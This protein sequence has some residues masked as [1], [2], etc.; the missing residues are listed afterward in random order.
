[1]CSSDLGRKV[2]TTVEELQKEFEGFV[3]NIDKK[4]YDEIEISYSRKFVEYCIAK[5]VKEFCS[6][7]LDEKIAD[8]SF[9]RFTF[10][11]MLAWEMPSSSHLQSSM[12]FLYDIILISC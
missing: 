2:G 4:E 7:K 5:A 1:M 6:D 10:D 3:W 8:G 9:S 11:A 12:V